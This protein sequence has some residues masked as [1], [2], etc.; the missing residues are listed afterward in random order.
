MAMKSC[1]AKMPDNTRYQID[2]IITPVYFRLSSHL[3]LVANNI[4]TC[5]VM[6]L[7]AKI[8]EPTPEASS[9]AKT[10]EFHAIPM[11]C[12]MFKHHVEQY[13]IQ[14]V[15]CYTGAQTSHAVF[16]WNSK[17]PLTIGG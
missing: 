1:L 17:M 4:D 8:I 14:Y 3:N 16:V 13:S 12:H 15:Y 7:F 9:L 2:N 11:Y 10:T 5:L 6:S